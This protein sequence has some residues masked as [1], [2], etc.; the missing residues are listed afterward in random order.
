MKV[1]VD[2]NLSPAWVPVL[3]EGGFDALH[4]TS[5]GDARAP[6]AEI[7]THARDHEQ[8]V[9]THDLD[10]GTL[11]ALARAA[12][13]SVV[14][15]RAQDVLPDVLS[16]LVLRALREHA[17]ALETGALVTIDAASSRVRILPIK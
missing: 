7:M 2:V 4:W 5:I 12:G 11:L 14:Q 3:I 9:F 10:F 6:D 8:V 15:V 1:L 17:Q 13:P 16:D